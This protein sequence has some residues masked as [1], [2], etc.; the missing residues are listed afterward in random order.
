MDRSTIDNERFSSPVFFLRPHR[1]WCTRA[2]S[3]RTPSRRTWRASTSTRLSTTSTSWSSSTRT[4]SPIRRSH[5]QPRTGARG[6]ATKKLFSSRPRRGGPRRRWSCTTFVRASRA[7]TG[8]QTNNDGWRCVVPN[9]SLTCLF[10]LRRFEV[11]LFWKL[12]WLSI[13][14]HLL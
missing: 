5:V 6:V 7:G 4:L 10:L 2:A 11:H 9:P 13:P 14:C 1:L 3:A 8:G 12:F